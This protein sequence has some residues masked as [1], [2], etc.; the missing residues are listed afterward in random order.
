MPGSEGSISISCLTSEFVVNGNDSNLKKF[1]NEDDSYVIDFEFESEGSQS[2]HF[3]VSGA[4]LK[5]NSNSISLSE[6]L[7]SSFSFDF[8]PFEFKKV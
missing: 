2:K 6:N 7:N 5:S 8:D 4:K 1:L 3:R